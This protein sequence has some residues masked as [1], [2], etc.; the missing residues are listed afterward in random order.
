[1][2]VQEKLILNYPLFNGEKVVENASVTIEN[3]RITAVREAETSDKNYFLMPGLMDAH[4]HINTRGQINAM[5][6]NGIAAACDVAAS[7]SLVKDSGK[8]TFISSAG[9]TMGTFCGKSYVKR[10][11]DDGAAYIKVL[12]MEPNL[13]PKLVLKDICQTAHEYSLKV[14]VHATSV[15]AVQMCIDCGVDILI[16]VPMKDVFPEKLAETIAQ[17]GIAI[18]PTLVMMRTFAYSNRNGYRPE[19]F[20]NAQN[21][22]RLLHSFGVRI[23]AATDSN[24]GSFSLAVPY[25]VSLHQE[26]ELLTQCGMT[27]IE[28]LAGATGNIA[29]TFPTNGC[30]M[31]AEGQKATLLL[32]EGRPDQCISDTKKIKQL[33][34]DGQPILGGKA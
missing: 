27:P 4:T 28:V 22:V 32:L 26:M 34:I 14:A 12:L 21:A 13:M 7:S 8:F 30:G 3:G 16:H 25:G 20:Q 15:K 33:W 23:L 18:A 31:I 6:E 2:K 5:L 1:M 24:D 10:A 9:M 11:I 19:H 17:K 29:K